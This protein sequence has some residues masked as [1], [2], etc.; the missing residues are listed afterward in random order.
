MLSSCFLSSFIEFCSVV[1]EE[2]L[3]MWKVN[4]GRMD[5]GQRVITIVHLSLRLR[6]TNNQ[7]KMIQE[8]CHLHC[9]LVDAWLCIPWYQTGL[10]CRC[11]Y[12]SSDTTF[13]ILWIQILQWW[14]VN[15]NTF[16]SGRNFRITEFS[17]LLK[18]P[19]VQK[20]KSVPA[21]FVR[22][23]EISG[24]SEPGLTNHHC[25]PQAAT[26]PGEFIFSLK[27][28]VKVTRSLTLV[29]FER[30]LLVEYAC[31]IWCLF[32]YLLWFKSYSEG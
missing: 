17:G 20:R 15:P 12:F 16:V 5:D 28:K 6:C 4:N 10:K 30:A 21:L 22:I 31:Q 3:K 24:L 7:M 19:S 13:C 8:N 32:D 27:V 2:K 11:K 29:S 9:I 25:I 18:R 1:S 23:S 26:K 14:F